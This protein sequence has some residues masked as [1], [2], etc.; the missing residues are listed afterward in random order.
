MGRKK[1]SEN[2]NGRVH[3]VYLTQ[4]AELVLRS[5]QRERRDRGFKEKG[6]LGR[7]V[8]DVILERFGDARAAAT[9]QEL[10]R[11]QTEQRLLEDRIRVLTDI[12]R[13]L[14]SENS[15]LF[16]EQ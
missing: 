11:L 13:N 12:Y 10:N 14:R 1:N 7:V 5:I 15:P 3:T 6:W 9:L 4:E 2:P 16:S 8:S